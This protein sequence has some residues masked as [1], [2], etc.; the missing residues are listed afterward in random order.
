M[1]DSLIEMLSDALVVAPLVET[2][3]HHYLQSV[4]VGASAEAK[5]AKLGS[6]TFFYVFA[7]QVRSSLPHSGAKS[8]LFRINLRS[9]I[10][11]RNVWEPHTTT[12]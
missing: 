11:S 7:Y 9:E 1:M 2:I 3:D 10:G 5:S 6:K 8:C 4:L 12:N